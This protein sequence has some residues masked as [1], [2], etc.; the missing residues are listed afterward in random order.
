MKT[1]RDVKGRFRKPTDEERWPNPAD[2]ALIIKARERFAEAE[3]AFRG[4]RDRAVTDL[5]FLSGEQW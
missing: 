1:Y 3:Q 5:V 2:Q 4:V